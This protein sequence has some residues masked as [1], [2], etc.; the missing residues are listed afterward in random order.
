[1]AIHHGADAL[2]LV[3]RMPSGP[4]PIEDDLIASIAKTIHPPVA[5]FL[6]TSHQSADEILNHVKKTGVNTV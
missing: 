4:G 2:G 1:M 6:L 3:G 5:S